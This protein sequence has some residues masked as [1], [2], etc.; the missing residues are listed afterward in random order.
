MKITALV[1]SI[2][3]LVPAAAHGASPPASAPSSAPATAVVPLMAGEVASFDGLLVPEATF[4]VFLRQKIDLEECTMRVAARDKAL[5]AMPTVP[6]V[7]PRPAVGGGFLAGVAVGV[8]GGVV[9]G[10]V[11]VYAATKVLAAG[12]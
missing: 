3:I 12:N 8:I 5:A 11:V 10:I 2:L 6:A 9:V 1:L 4:V 7:A